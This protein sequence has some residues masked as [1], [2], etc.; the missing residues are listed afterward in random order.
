[1]GVAEPPVAIDARYHRLPEK[2]PTSR[3]L[4]RGAEPDQWAELAK[5]I[6]HLYQWAEPV[7]K[8]LIGRR[9][10]LCRWTEPAVVI[11]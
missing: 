11:G 7:K 2:T 10:F 8:K 3:Q 1:V 6:G 9:P 5:L 4:V